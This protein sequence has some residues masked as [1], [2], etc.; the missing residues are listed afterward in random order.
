LES[1]KK[2]NADEIFGVGLL[3]ILLGVLS[4]IIGNFPP[5]PN[6]ALVGIGT[7]LCI[8]GVPLLLVGLAKGVI[9]EEPARTEK[10]SAYASNPTIMKEKEVIVKEVVMIPCKYCGGLMPQTAIF[11]PNCGAQRKN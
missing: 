4:A 6:S 8:I 7:F 5:N 10:F 11:C 3:L 2:K 1:E 9:L